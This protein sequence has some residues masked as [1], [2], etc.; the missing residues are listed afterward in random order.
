MP[1]YSDAS[2]IEMLPVSEVFGLNRAVNPKS[3]VVRSIEKSF[4]DS[5]D[6]GGAV[7][8]V[9]YGMSKQGK[10]SLLRS[11]LAGRRYIFLQANRGVSCEAVYTEMLSQCGIEQETSHSRSAGGSAGAS[12]GWFRIS[13]DAKGTQ[14]RTPVNI[15]IANPDSVAR[16]LAEADTG[17]HII[18][19]DNFH[20]FDEEVQRQFATAIRSFETYG[21]KMIVIGTWSETGYLTGF[22]RDIAATSRE[23]SFEEWSFGELQSVLAKGSP[24]LKVTFSY[25]VQQS[26]IHRSVSNVAL[27]QELTRQYL[28]AEGIRQTAGEPTELTDVQKV[29]DVANDMEAR[30]ENDTKRALR[31]IAGIGDSNPYIDGKSRSWWILKAFLACRSEQILSGVP[32]AELLEAAN[33][34]AGQRARQLKQPFVPLSEMDFMGLIKHHWQKEQVRELKSPIILYNDQTK[35]LV[36]VDAWVKFVLRGARRSSVRNDL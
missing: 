11:A 14:T 7:L 23:F 28:I 9:V 36:I 26:L 5:L 8:L 16:V 33:D 19:I 30:L 35:K 15:N 20:Y 32:T 6:D 31:F 18:V 2:E 34:I 10:S 4:H 12:F 1:A 13:V 27:L 3:Y 25:P 24:A 21:F 22:N 29:G 17:R